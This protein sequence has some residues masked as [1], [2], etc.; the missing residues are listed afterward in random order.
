MSTRAN[1]VFLDGKI[2]ELWFYR[3]SDGYPK[4][5]LPLLKT[6]MAK[7]AKGEIRDNPSQSAGW[8]VVL[9]HCEYEIEGTRDGWK[10]GSIEPTD[11]MH[12]DIEYLYELNLKAREI[13]VYVVG[14]PKQKLTKLGKVAFDK[15]GWPT[16]S[17]KKLEEALKT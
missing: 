6:F 2:R 12:G 15:S 4:G 5:A 7:V 13:N 8:L 9:G 3:H 17:G 1:I 14:Y 11:A 10:V 16:Y